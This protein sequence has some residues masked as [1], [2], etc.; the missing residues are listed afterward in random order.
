MFFKDPRSNAVM[1]WILAI[2]GVL[3]IPAAIKAGLL[4]PTPGVVIC[5]L[6]ALFFG[7]RWFRFRAKEKA[8][9]K[10]SFRFDN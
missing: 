2:F 7:T 10:P 8:T 9:R 4:P 5:F 3:N 6:L 1:A